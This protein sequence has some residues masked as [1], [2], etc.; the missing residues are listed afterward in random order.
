MVWRNNLAAWAA[1]RDASLTVN[2]FMQGAV[3]LSEETN[4]SP[5][6]QIPIDAMLKQV[7]YKKFRICDGDNQP[8]F[9]RA[10]YVD[11]AGKF[12]IPA[13]LIERLGIVERALIDA[14]TITT[15]VG[16]VLLSILVHNPR[17]FV[18]QVQR[19]N[20][21]N[22][23]I[24]VPLDR[25]LALQTLD[26]TP[27]VDVT[28]GRMHTPTQ[29]LELKNVQ[30]SEM[31]TMNDIAGMRR[32]VSDIIR[33]KTLKTVMLLEGYTVDQLQ[34]NT[35]NSDNSLPD[36]EQS[37]EQDRKRQRP[38]PELDSML[39]FRQGEQWLNDQG[40]TVPDAAPT[41]T[42]ATA[43]TQAINRPD[44]FSNSGPSTIPPSATI[45]L[46]PLLTNPIPIP[47]SQPHSLSQNLST[48]SSLS[49]QQFNLNS[50]F[51]I[52]NPVP[53]QQLLQPGRSSLAPQLPRPEQS[54][55]A[56]QLPQ[57][58]QLP[59][60]GHGPLAPQLPQ[61]GQNSLA[62]QLLQLP[63]PLQPRQPVQLLDNSLQ[64]HYLGLGS[65]QVLPQPQQ[66]AH[67]QPTGLTAPTHTTTPHIF[68]PQ[69]PLQAFLLPLFLLP[70]FLL[71]FLFFPPYFRPS[72]FRPLLPL[73][74]LKSCPRKA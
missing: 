37:A 43:S 48:I 58:L 24:L 62:S 25:D 27:V 15:A 38:N 7:K 10:S 46:V 26:L 30:P 56:S 12:N 6:W 34:Q 49:N 64:A 69:V 5:A 66:Q 32:R 13:Q 21:G 28:S 50:S 11:F 20:M 18:T 72:L 40:R 54:F 33:S 29:G 67:N 41:P 22:I 68:P 44:L 36:E 61:P 8:R 19:Q 17:R 71:P 39:P 45:P 3:V 73:H 53:A 55:P 63:Q 52:P 4:L 65:P 2:P 47:P 14:P 23:F 60:S 31:I 1:R 74:L 16:Q 59:Q 70:S 51:L 35:V 9:A 57:P 42:S